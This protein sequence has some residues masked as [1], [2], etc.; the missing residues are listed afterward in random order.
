MMSLS[1]FPDSRDCE[2]RRLESWGERG[3]VLRP[4]SWPLGRPLTGAR[5]LELW[6]GS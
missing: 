5:C 3:S 4:L 2:A 6:G 1:C